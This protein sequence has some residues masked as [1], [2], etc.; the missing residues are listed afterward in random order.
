MQR[1]LVLLRSRASAAGLPPLC[2]YRPD[3]KL[4]FPRGGSQAMVQ[5]LVRCARHAIVLMAAV[6]GPQ[7]IP[8][9]HVHHSRLIL[10]RACALQGPGEAWRAAA[11]QLS[12]KRG[13]AGGRQGGRWAW[14]LSLQLQ[15][16]ARFAGLS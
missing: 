7:Y 14:M 3:C 9:L 4:E 12:C 8:A 15:Q 10:N 16:F 6:P 11:A 5:A 1:A 2:R 13:V